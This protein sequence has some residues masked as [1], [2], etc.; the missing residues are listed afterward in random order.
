[1]TTDVMR[2]RNVSL[3]A[4][5]ELIATSSV[6]KWSFE[7]IAMLSYHLILRLTICGCR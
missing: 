3:L 1:M 5:L 2:A 6:T 7:Q 4:A